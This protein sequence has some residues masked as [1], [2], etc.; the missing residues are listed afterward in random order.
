M[1][2]VKWGD[3]C[4]DNCRQLSGE[5]RTIRGEEECVHVGT[6]T[7]ALLHTTHS[8][9]IRTAA[10]LVSLV[11]DYSNTRKKQR[12]AGQQRHESTNGLL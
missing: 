6:M 9:C 2:K 10:E 11:I 7:T 4:A 3:T 5:W 12:D 8:L 1:Q